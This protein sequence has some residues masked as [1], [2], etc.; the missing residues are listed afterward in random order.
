[1]EL[2]ERKNTETILV[3]PQARIE[4][5]LLSLFLLMIFVVLQGAAL[6]GLLYTSTH[7]L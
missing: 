3:L 1:M 7:G 4:P 2:C 6:W 5:V